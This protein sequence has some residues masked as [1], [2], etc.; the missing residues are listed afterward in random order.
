MHL[1]N[2]NET[3]ADPLG[4]KCDGTHSWETDAVNDRYF[5]RVDDIHRQ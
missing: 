2:E 4:E 5:E 3:H 1:H